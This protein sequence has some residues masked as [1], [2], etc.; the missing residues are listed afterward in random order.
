[1]SENFE[2]IILEKFYTFEQNQNEQL[3]FNENVLEKLD[4]ISNDLKEYKE[5]LDYVS[6][7][8]KEYKEKLDYVSN[9]LKE[10]KEKL[11]YVS[12]DLRSFSRHFAVFED[13]FSR[14]VDV[15]FENY[16]T[17]FNQHKTFKKDID[18]LKDDSFKYGVQIEH[19]S[20]RIANV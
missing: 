8:L 16:S 19:L 11:D 9:D 7:D 15:L 2:K 1:M 6:N 18:S 14:K 20:K 5:K 4:I 17:D 13:D 10:Y 3:K 12:N